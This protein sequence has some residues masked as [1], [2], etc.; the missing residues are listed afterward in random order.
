[1]RHPPRILLAI[2]ALA[3]VILPAFHAGAD[4]DSALARLQRLAHEAAIRTASDGESANE[5]DMISYRRHLM[6]QPGLQLYVVFFNDKGQPVD[7]FVTVGKCTSSTKRLTRPWKFVQGQTGVDKDNNAVYG[8]FVMP[9]A[10]EDGTFGASDPYVYCKTAEGKY[11]QWNG[12][13]YASDA[14]IELTIKPLVVDFS[15]KN[16]QQQ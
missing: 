10:S 7:Y 15:G 4:D 9:T 2:A 8:D 5:I 14:P 3:A 6:S 13:Y 11:K 12:K 1:M 16:Q